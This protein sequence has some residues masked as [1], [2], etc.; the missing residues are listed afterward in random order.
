MLAMLATRSMLIHDSE[1]GREGWAGVEDELNE[2]SEESFESDDEGAASAAALDSA[3]SAWASIGSS[4][5]NE[6]EA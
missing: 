6:C 3:T 2:G 1:K 5:K 4:S